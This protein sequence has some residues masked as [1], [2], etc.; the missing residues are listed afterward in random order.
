M[1]TLRRKPKLSPNLSYGEEV[2]RMKEKRKSIKRVG[3]GGKIMKLVL[4]SMSL[5]F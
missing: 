5:R 2:E 1:T 4:D 3:F